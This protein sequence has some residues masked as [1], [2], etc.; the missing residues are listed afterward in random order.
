MASANVAYATNSFST[1][2][3]DNTSN[4]TLFG[5]IS[6][7]ADSWLE[8]D[9]GSGFVQFGRTIHQ[10]GE[11]SAQVPNLQCGRSYP[12]RVGAI[13]PNNG[14][15]VFGQTFNLVVNCSNNNNNG[16]NNN[17]VSVTTGSFNTSQN[18]AT[19]F[20][21]VSTSADSWIEANLGNGTQ[22]FGRTTHSGSYSAFLSGL[23]CNSTYFYRAAAQGNNG[24]V[25]GDTRSFTTSSC[26]NFNNN[27]FNNNNF[28]NNNFNN[29]N[30]NNNN[31]NN[32]L[33]STDSAN[34]SQ[35]S[36]TAFA[37][38][39]GSADS[40]IEA[41]LGNGTQQ[42][43]RSNRSSGS[44]SVFFSGLQCNSTYFYR[45]AAQ[46]NNGIIYGQTRSFTTSSC[47]NNFNNNNNNNTSL[48]TI[49]TT[50]TG[51]GITTARLN[52]LALVSSTP[53][54]GYFE[55]GT[56][57]NLGTR[58][59]SRTYFESN[60]V[61]LLD[62]IS[63]LQPD[64]T[65]FYRAVA[66]NSQGIAN[67]DIMSFR[68]ASVG[69]T[70]I[71]T[72]TVST[73]TNTVTRVVNSVVRTVTG[74]TNT[75]STNANGVVFVPVQLANIGT[76][77]AVG[78]TGSTAVPS[79]ATIS[80]VKSTVEGCNNTF[81]ITYTNTSDK[82]LSN[83]LISTALP[84]EL[85]FVTASEGSFRATDNTLTVAVGTLNAR[86]SR[87]VTVTAKVLEGAQVGK[88]V[89]VTSYLN[90][91]DGATTAQNQVTGYTL[92]ELGEGC[93]TTVVSAT[94]G[95]GAAGL[96]GI[97]PSSLWQWLAVIIA[98]IL[99]VVAGRSLFG[100]TKSTAVH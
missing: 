5:T 94:T 6:A 30:F 97:L 22:Q 76:V 26:N 53:T 60:S 81:V 35:N 93:A 39:S 77:G 68:T 43:G 91:T 86:E 49:T 80:V 14:S 25:F 10:S 20:G 66:Q 9:R 58:T 37:S 84:N 12:Y 27:N 74:N 48:R 64:T 45:A 99:I 62:N 28:N 61:P 72:P 90:Y 47:N 3:G 16:N 41:N 57:Q 19:V 2:N 95:A 71:N 87:T 83:V 32:V 11:F 42:F 65:Y 54:Q 69:T 4:A 96:S 82:V 23:Q 50:A 17:F 7:Q 46:S 29:N 36:A 1:P 92:L 21:S 56:S 52:G 8:L 67:G 13:N 63:G 98:I 40:W 33:V 55:Y 15:T 51:V 85:E 24:V 38:I 34:V 88:T 89:A 75:A 78:A 70:V 73:P 31:F 100:G 59:A 18:S 44:Y 79:L